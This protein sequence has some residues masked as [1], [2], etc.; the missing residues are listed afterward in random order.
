MQTSREEGMANLDARLNEL[1]RGGK[2]SAEEAK[3]FASDQS[4]V[5]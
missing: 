3:K 5:Q 2:V 1:V 4:A